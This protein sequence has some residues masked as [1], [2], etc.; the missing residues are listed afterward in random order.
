MTS[1]TGMPL[2][3]AFSGRPVNKPVPKPKSPNRW[4]AATK[5]CMTAQPRTINVLLSMA[6]GDCNICKSLPFHNMDE[7]Y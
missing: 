5:L 2:P 1:A 7:I 6:R 4:S 3:R